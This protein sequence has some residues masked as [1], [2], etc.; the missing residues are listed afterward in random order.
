METLDLTITGAS[1]LLMHSDRGANPLDPKTKAHKVLT[2]KRKKTDEDH[3]AI[4]R[5][6]WEMGMYFDKD[7]GPYLPTQNVMSCITNGAK[8][9]KLG[10][11]VAKAAMILD[12]KTK[13]IYKGPR[14]IATLWKDPRFV[15]CRSV[16]VSRARIMRY[17]PSFFPWAIEVSI[18]FD[19]EIIERQQ[20]LDAAINAGRFVGLGDFRPEKKGPFGRFNVTA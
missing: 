6:E 14:T 18:I 17:R 4:A 13:L 11:T 1:P 20:I 15:D 19:T 3:E 7:F 10:S 2:S 8:M 9:H 12:E 16:V 5:S